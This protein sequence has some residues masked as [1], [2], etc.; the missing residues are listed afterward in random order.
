MNSERIKTDEKPV[1]SGLFDD[2]NALLREGERVDDL[3]FK[4]L[5]LIQSPAAFCFGTDSVLLT[6]FA[7][8]AIARA[9][10]GACIVDMGSGSGAISLLL[11]AKT[12]LCVTAVEI[13]EEQ[14]E[15]FSRTLALN[16]IKT[17]GESEGR[18]DVGKIQ[19]VCADYLSEGFK[20]ERKFDHAVCN[21]P[22][23]RLGSGGSP[24]NAGATH[25]ESADIFSIAEAARRLLKYGGSFSLCFPAERLA[26][27]L[28]ALSVNALE[29]KTLRLVRT[30]AG[31]KPY[32]ALIRAKH[33]AKPGLIV[34]DELTVLDEDGKYTP[35]VQ[36]YYNG[37]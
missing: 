36:R 1:E 16:G 12:G 23:F 5:R 22:Y 15:R 7:L 20:F 4:R 35:E 28:T 30:K 14:C 27:A 19:I 10:R 3:Q 17:E 24:K 2:A 29:P 31:K 32:L 37:E 11:A 13:D 8:G 33:G 25:E 21:P 18:G 26:E 9:K 6:H 34:E